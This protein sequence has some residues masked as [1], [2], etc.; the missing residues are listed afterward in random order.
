MQVWAITYEPSTFTDEIYRSGLL[1]MDP[2]S[3]ARIKKFYRRED[4]CRCLIG[5]LLP[6]MLLKERG[7]AWNAMTFASTK[8]GKPYIT[9]PD[10]NP[11]I[12]FNVSH[13][14]ALVTM[15]FGPGTD[16]PPAFRIGVDIMKVELPQRDPFPQFVKMFSDQLTAVETHAVLSVP[17]DEGLRRFFWIWTMKEAYTKALG[18]G[19]GFDFKRIEYDVAKNILT[20]DGSIPKGWQLV[21]FEI[22]HG[23]DVYQGVAAN[24]IGGNETI[25]LSRFS[26]STN[27]VR[28]DATT[29]VLRALDE[30]K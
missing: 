4:A 24:F 23:M 7:V 27:L 12:A 20:V 5:R 1:L 29:F 28:Y 21:K 22:D 9:T 17:E 14:N 11:S 15:A 30:L 13:D 2:D 26:E 18:L 16:D 19:M 25:V 6:R 8:V 10:V 3:Q